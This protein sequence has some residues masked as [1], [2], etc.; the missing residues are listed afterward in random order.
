V[1]DL[2]PGEVFSP[3]VLDSLRTPEEI[4]N[5]LTE[6]IGILKQHLARRPPP[7]TTELSSQ[8][9]FQWHNSFW[10]F[11]G[12]AIG[13]LEMAAMCAMITRE[14]FKLMMR[15]IQGTMLRRESTVII[16]GE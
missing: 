1:S 8:I 14:E 15:S 5:Y 9:Y 6:R 16:A 13:C 11:Y 7:P 2:D 12:R 10:I 4:R 3:S